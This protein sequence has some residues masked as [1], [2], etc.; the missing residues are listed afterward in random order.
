MKEPMFRNA[1]PAWYPEV[2]RTLARDYPEIS[3]KVWSTT[4]TENA[5]KNVARKAEEQ[6][7]T[8]AD[9]TAPTDLF[10]QSG[11]PV[12]VPGAFRGLTAAFQA[13]ANQSSATCSPDNPIAQDEHLVAAVESCAKCRRPFDPTDTKMDGAAQQ[14]ATP[15]CRECVA[16]CHDT[17]IA[18]HWCVIDQWRDKA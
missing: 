14:K 10:R 2:L 6:P 11:P 13:V 8:P 17:E 12:A 15:F 16:R 4:I 9:A 7:A 3:D 1:H 18:D 5:Q